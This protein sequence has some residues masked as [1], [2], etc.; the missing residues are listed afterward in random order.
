MQLDEAVLDYL[1]AI[2]GY[3]VKSSIVIRNFST[4]LTVGRQQKFFQNISNDSLIVSGTRM[5]LFGKTSVGGG[6]QGQAI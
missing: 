1:H 4:S 2:V 6:H 3:A 5:N